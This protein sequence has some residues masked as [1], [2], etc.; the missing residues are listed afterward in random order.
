VSP[1]TDGTDVE[2]GFINVPAGARLGDWRILRVLGQGRFGRVYEAA[3][4]RPDGARSPGRMPA[5]AALKVFQDA[6]L[7]S[8]LAQAELTKEAD[9]MASVTHPNVLGFY[10]DVTLPKSSAYAGTRFFVLEL[11]DHDLLEEASRTPSGLPA[12]EVLEIATDIAAG[13]KAVHEMYVHGDVK[14]E[15]IIKVDRLYKLGDM[16][17]AARLEGTGAYPRPG[18]MRYRPPEYGRRRGSRNQTRWKER[19]GQPYDIWGLGITLH[20]VLTKR[21]PYEPPGKSL[22]GLQVFE[23]VQSARLPTIDVADPILRLV[24][25]R[26]LEV[27]EEQRATAEELLA[28]LGKPA[29]FVARQGTRRSRASEALWHVPRP[30]DQVL[31]GRAGA[32][33][34]LRMR[35]RSDP[36]VNLVG[37]DGVGKRQLAAA[38]AHRQADDYDVVWWVRAGGPEAMRYDCATL[39]QAL[40]LGDA[41]G[42]AP[43]GPEAL[44]QWLLAHDRWLVVLDDGAPDR[45]LGAVPA[46]GRGHVLV[47][48]PT[49]AP[50]DVSAIEVTTLRREDSVALL[51]AR[52]GEGDGVSADLLAEALGDLP[53]A[54]DIAAAFVELQDTLADYLGHLRRRAPELLSEPTARDPRRVVAAACEASFEQVQRSS[55]AALELLRLCA[56]L[57]PDDIPLRLLVENA[58]A[59]P[60]ALQRLVARGTPDPAIAL[61]R[62]LSLVEQSHDALSVHH[63]VQQALRDSLGPGGGQ[64]WSTIAV[65]ALSASLP[66]TADA[67]TQ[68]FSRRLLPH[69][70]AAAD[71]AEAFEAEA[72]DTTALLEQAAAIVLGDGHP[73]EAVHH[74]DRAV[75]VCESAYGPDHTE[76]GVHAFNLGNVLCEVGERHRGRACLERSL[77]IAEA[78]DG[79]DHPRVGERLY[80]LGRLLRELGDDSAARTCLERSV[81]VAEETYGPDSEEVGIRLDD[82]GLALLGTGEYEAA[83]AR[84][85]RSLAIVEGDFGADHPQ[86]G[87]VLDNLG[88]ALHGLG[89]D[90]SAC[91]C[92]ERSLAI[93][94]SEYAPD[95]SEV[96]SRLN[97]LGMALNALGH[98]VEARRHLEQALAGTDV[99]LGPDHPEVGARRT[100][101]GVALRGTGDHVAARQHLEAAVAIS[102]SVHGRDHPEVGERLNNLGMVL[103]DL[104]DHTAARQAFERSLAI[105]EASSGPAHPDVG[106]R[107]N[108]LALAMLNLGDYAGARKTLRAGVTVP[109]PDAL[110]GEPLVSPQVEDEPAGT[111]ENADAAAGAVVGPEGQ[112]PTD[113]E[114]PDE[115]R[116]GDDD[117]DL[118]SAMPLPPEAPPA[119]QR[120]SGPSRRWILAAIGVGIITLLS[121][122]AGVATR[123][124]AVIDESTVV[125]MAIDVSRSMQASDVAPSRLEA[126]KVGAQHFVEGIP[127][128]VRIGLVSFSGR[129]TVEAPP[130]TDHSLLKRNIDTLQLGQATAVGEAIYASLGEIAAVPA[131]PSQTR[132]QARIVLLSDGATTVG[133]ANK[134]AAR[135]A[136]DAH[137]PVST[138]AFGT[139]TGT[140]MVE[141]NPVRVPVNKDAL[142]IIADETGGSFLEASSAKG[143][144]RAYNE[145][146]KALPH[147]TTGRHG[148]TFETLAVAV[149]VGAAS[150]A[151]VWAFGRRR[152]GGDLPEPSGAPPL[153]ERSDGEFSP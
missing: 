83:R 105:A 46:A 75:R 73:G 93:A 32:L 135:A 98:Y 121:T 63:L 142:H 64:E 36:V 151:V 20:E 31:Y 81:A 25:E 152:R 28:I 45:W 127:S 117:P 85:E 128:R 146:G 70:L 122:V 129:V 136:V 97:H 109:S 91:T 17:V 104:G 4:E 6:L 3:Y 74:L 68:G 62:R 60:K 130:T 71:H 39:A 94:R 33:Q 123:P 119:G 132:P 13:L 76:V 140:V 8:P 148:V 114:E 134:D 51:L 78:A 106:T 138:I 16:G 7:L 9:A 149:C 42:A 116:P 61:L 131:Q 87:L 48:G 69:I 44:Q 103:H 35:L 55:R 145:I 111:D 10:G 99:A 58:S 12:G 101:L 50:A 18:T 96:A 56:F 30:E 27:D 22:D 92:F 26:C 67:D 150:A 84:F 113:F 124:S 72:D 66:G 112:L 38:H 54:L 43:A 1:D 110:P 90:G 118:S 37:V 65:R 139:Q 100:N 89:D 34:E 77:R 47:T 40:G 88:M 23:T 5:R 86:V 107:R 143:L 153:A 141:G 80:V 15:N 102:E 137:T 53:L 2:G 144:T 108:N 147:R 82:L 59:L 57:G 115:A 79:P 21:H 52:S 120:S 14:P 49:P 41:A 126:A 11:G 19:V 95:H 29:G 125:V 24:I 133:R